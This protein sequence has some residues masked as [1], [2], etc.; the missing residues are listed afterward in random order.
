MYIFAVHNRVQIEN[1]LAVTKHLPSASFKFFQSANGVMSDSP[2]ET[3]R[4]IPGH[5]AK[6][7]LR[8][9]RTQSFTRSDVVIVPQDLGLAWRATAETARR[10]GSLL[11]LMPDGIVSSLPVL[12]GGITKRLGRTIATSPLVA[13]GLLSRSSGIMGGSDPNLILRWGSAWSQSFES[14]DNAIDVGCP[15]MD[16]LAQIGPRPDNLKLLVCSQPMHLSSW[17]RPFAAEWYAFLLKLI[18]HSTDPTSLRVRLHPA[19]NPD[20]LPS[21]LRDAIA[22]PRSLRDDIEWASVVAAPFSTVLLEASVAGRAAIQ[23]PRNRPMHAMATG[24]PFFTDPEVTQCSWDQHAL[25]E[26]ARTA[27]PLNNIDRFAAFVGESGKRVAL[28]LQQLAQ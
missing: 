22:P 6:N 9:I 10:R 3:Q 24:Y 19:E 1:A 7:V 14:S 25:L 21:P 16:Q 18:Q 15:R 23:L 20:R 11:A 27:T 17:T 26:L 4:H 2:P 28:A 5:S 12:R 8:L 13:A